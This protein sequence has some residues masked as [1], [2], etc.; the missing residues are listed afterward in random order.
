V[1]NPGDITARIVITRHSGDQLTIDGGKLIFN[2]VTGALIFKPPPKG[3][4]VVVSQSMEGLHMGRFAGP[5]LRWFLFLCSLI[6]C[7]MVA[8]GLVLWTVKR[9]QDLPDPDR[10]YFGFRLVERMNIGTIAGVPAGMAAML[11]ANRLLPVEMAM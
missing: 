11:W 5:P 8:T 2:G 9:R 6:G 10:P 1:Q 3:P 7:V 4:G